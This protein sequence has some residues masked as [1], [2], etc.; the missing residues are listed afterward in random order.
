MNYHDYLDSDLGELTL[1]IFSLVSTS[2]ILRLGPTHPTITAR[3]YHL[4]TKDDNFQVRKL[5]S[6]D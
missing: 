5:N 2:N 4:E 6:I 1:T 3:L